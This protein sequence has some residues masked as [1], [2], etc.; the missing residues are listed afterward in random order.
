MPGEDGDERTH[1]DQRKKALPGF[2]C[3]FSLSK[4]LSRALSTP[5]S[6]HGIGVSRLNDS[7]TCLVELTRTS[8]RLRLRSGLRLGRG[9]RIDKALA[10]KLS[11]QSLATTP[12]LNKSHPFQNLQKSF[13]PGVRRAPDPTKVLLNASP[14]AA[15]PLPGAG[16][17]ETAHG[18][19]A[20]PAC[21]A[22]DSVGVHWK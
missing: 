11:R 5:F 1:G 22:L 20:S 14:A 15:R 4:T 16:K 12:P 7:H 18:D 17:H 13:V 9:F 6:P 21:N 19:V 10:T 3:V 2:A 8:A